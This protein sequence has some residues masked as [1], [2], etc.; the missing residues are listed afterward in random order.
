MCIQK[1]AV[2]L[3]KNCFYC[4]LREW[5]RQ[6]NN[7]K[8]KSSKK[9]LESKSSILDT[10]AA[11]IHTTAPSANKNKTIINQKSIYTNK[12]PMG[13]NAMH[14]L[15]GTL[16]LSLCFLI[17]SSLSSFTL[18]SS[19]LREN[20]ANGQRLIYNVLTAIFF[21]SSFFL[22]TY[23]IRNEFASVARIHFVVPVFVCTMI[24]PFSSKSKMLSIHGDCSVFSV[25][26]WCFIE[27]VRLWNQNLPNFNRR[28]G[29]SS[30]QLQSSCSLSKSLIMKN[31]TF[32]EEKKKSEIP[33][34]NRTPWQEAVLSIFSKSF[35]FLHF[36][37]A[38]LSLAMLDP[39]FY[40]LFFFFAFVVRR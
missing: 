16:I 29:S 21:F 37:C 28:K 8:I 15:R 40:W 24:F 13:V 26:R 25:F 18:R 30:K 4:S 33:I 3:N 1:R 35:L 39:F 27:S 34:R 36:F 7:Y 6:S 9:K 20:E 17:P 2:L 32:E 19:I 23:G 10:V 14:W 31:C 11:E 38:S 5:K 12:S 22:F